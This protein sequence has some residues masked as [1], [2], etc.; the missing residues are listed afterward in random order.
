MERDLSQTPAQDIAY[1]LRFCLRI[2]EAQWI[3]KLGAVCL[4]RASDFASDPA[5]FYE[6]GVC[7]MHPEIR[8]YPMAEKAFHKV[9]VLDLSKNLAVKSQ[10]YLA[11]L[12]IQFLGK[13]DEGASLLQ[14]IPI[15]SLAPQENRLLKVLQAEILLTQGETKKASEILS[16]ITGK[17]TQFHKEILKRKAALERA[18][19][20]FVRKEYNDAEATV[21]EIEE[22]SP[23]EK[24]SPDLSLLLVQI[25]LGRKEYLPA[26]ALCR[27][28]LHN[29]TLDR[30][31]AQT[32][33]HLIEIKK[34]MGSLKEAQEILHKLTKE[35]PYSEAAAIAKAKWQ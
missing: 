6:L 34:S 12:L 18:K 23:M 4:T 17:H 3:E 21:R 26:L 16:S 22:V 27:R 20:F 8:N 7:S 31:K 14:S 15:T 11:Q 25:H 30:H 5:I 35:Y 19:D 1:L 32:L 29:A 9:L 24:L 13:L 33:L 10:L 2:R 28:L